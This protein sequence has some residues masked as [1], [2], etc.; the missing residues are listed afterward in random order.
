MGE[1]RWTL[2]ALDDLDLIKEYI[3]QDSPAQASMFGDRLIEATRRL[4]E[5][6]LSGKVTP[7]TGDR[8]RRE[9]RVGDYRVMYRVEGEHVYITRVFH[10]ARDFKL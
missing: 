7:E 5:F 6:P 8:A 1:V 2:A 9:V 4:S 10:G 3:A